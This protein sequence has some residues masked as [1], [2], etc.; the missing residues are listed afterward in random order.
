L[1]LKEEFQLKEE[2]I[3]MFSWPKADKRMINIGLEK[4]MNIVQ[5]VIQGV[6]YSREKIHQG[7][8]WPLKE[9]TIISTDKDVLKAV[10]K[11]GDIVKKQTNVKEIRVLESLPGIKQ[12]V[13]ADY[14][15]IGPEFGAKSAEIIAHIST[16]SPETILKQ[17]KEKGKYEFKA[18]SDKI[19]VNLNHLIIDREVP[20]PFTESEI[21]LGL[22]E[23]QGR[24]ARYWARNN[25][26]DWKF[27]K[28]LTFIVNEVMGSETDYWITDNNRFVILQRM[29]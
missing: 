16:H 5:D 21:K 24:K 27:E 4:E 2:S 29:F 23:D 25:F 8:K 28:E 22:S 13:K 11:L 10:E 20:K 1:N 15:K 17:I 12:I 19:S 18:G 6:L 14:A 9:I 3:H 26:K 7:L